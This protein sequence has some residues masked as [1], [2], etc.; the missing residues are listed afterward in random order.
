MDFNQSQHWQDSYA[1][2]FQNHAF[3]EN[4]E[5]FNILKFSQNM[6]F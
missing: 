2:L 6:T 4:Y 1:F 5:F 3:S